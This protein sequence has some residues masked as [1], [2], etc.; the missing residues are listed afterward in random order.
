[1]AA[2][3]GLDVGTSGTKGVAIDERGVVTGGA[4]A[5]HGG[6][7]SG[8]GVSEQ[9]PEDWV[10]SADAV[11]SAL[12]LEDPD[13]L[14]LTGQMHGLVL[15]D[16]RGRVLR[17]AILW[18]DGRAVREREELEDR[19]GVPALLAR[20]GNRAL[21]GV[22]APSL[23]WVRRHEPDVWR[24]IRHVLLP[25]DY[26]RL[27]LGGGLG[28]G[29]PTT[30]VSDASGTL[31]FDVAAREWSVPM[32]DELGVDPA[33]LPAVAESHE[34]VGRTPGGVPLAAG[35]GDQAAAALGLGLTPGGPLGVALGT[36]GVVM[37]VGTSPALVDPAGRLQTLCAARPEGWQTMA[38]TLSAA[39]SLAWWDAVAGG[40]A[41]GVGALVAAAGDR[42]AGGDGLVF[43]PYLRGERAPHMDAAARGA[44][45]GL[46]AHHDR[47]A[48][49]R[50]VVEGV[51]F[52]LADAH[53]LLRGAF[54][55]PAA[56][57][58]GGAARSPVVREILAAV[59]GLRLERV[60]VDEA[61]AYGA[62]LLAAI[63]A[64]ALA[65][66]AEASTLVRVEGAEEPDGELRG[67][68]AELRARYRAL[69]P[70][71]RDA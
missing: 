41:D 15:L 33:W 35:A 71:L 65:D 31:L 1:V 10:R 21:P 13:G 56:R 59:L 6:P 60:A 11:L 24:R 61:P 32:L 3:V 20:T 16:G 47:A 18:N 53:D 17:P 57:V 55:A 7:P 49:T 36:S 27:R 58:T 39:G 8:A 52:S 69:Y 9:D 42:S 34:V 46:A 5:A 22:T 37:G 43:L 64:G 63:A 62:A 28:A 40:D 2:F 12:R 38:V 29:D 50:A 26:V 68:Y 19:P 30:D 51:A 44:F 48:L 66:H 54:A 25:K 45:V 14:A 67:R 4:A 70:A 23:R